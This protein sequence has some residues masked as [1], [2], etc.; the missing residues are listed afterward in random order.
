MWK[1]IIHQNDEAKLDYV[2]WSEDGRII[3]Q[4]KSYSSDNACRKGIASVTKNSRT[5]NLD[6][7][8][9]G[10]PV[11]LSKHPKYEVYKQKNGKVYFQL[12]ASNGQ[13]VG[14]SAAYSSREECLAVV[15]ELRAQGSSAIVEG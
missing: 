10:E 11:K 12:K 5:N 7:Y 14:V 9:D 15:A 3:L 8:S 4:S 13:I 6:D 2:L 1:F